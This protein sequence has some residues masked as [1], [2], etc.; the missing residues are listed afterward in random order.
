M[1][2][3]TVKVVSS[4]N[5]GGGLRY[6]SE[7]V[8]E[9]TDHLQQG[10]TWTL[11]R[12]YS[13][14]ESLHYRVFQL[15]GE[16]RLKEIGLQFPEKVHAGSILG[17][18]KAITDERVNQ[19]QQYIDVLVNVVEMEEILR[20]ERVLPAF[21]DFDHRGI[22]GA[23]IELGRDKILQ[24]GYMQVRLSRKFAFL[25]LWSVQYVVL[26]NTG[27]LVVLHS[28]YDRVST[29]SVLSQPIATG[30]CL[31]VPKA[32]DNTIVVTSLENTSILTLAFNSPQ[33]S[34]FWI[35]ALSNFC[36]TTEAPTAV[37]SNSNRSGNNNASSSNT[38]SSSTTISRATASNSNTNE[39][40]RNTSNSHV[41][42]VH[43][44]GTGHT[45]DDLSNLLGV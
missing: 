7:F 5:I 12:R 39:N 30:K 9:V 42:N 18:L 29:S 44:A 27:Y 8:L 43:A 6:H 33:E 2:S 15:L 10:A 1:S 25:G 35:R 22:S 36:N 16:E 21:L 32:A 38:R 13:A 19:L 4:V 37:S 40:N 11:Y 28:M 31:V 20:N 3:V 17:T 41:E 34:V 45:Q 14:F 24:Q 26:L 23:E